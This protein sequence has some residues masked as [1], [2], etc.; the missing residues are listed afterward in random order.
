MLFENCSK[1]KKRLTKTVMPN[2]SIWHQL[3]SIKHMFAMKVIYEYWK[4]YKTK[5]SK[6]HKRRT[7]GY[8]SS[9][10]WSLLVEKQR[11]PK[12]NAI[13]CCKVYSGHILYLLISLLYAYLAVKLMQIR[14]HCYNIFDRYE[15]TLVHMLGEYCLRQWSSILKEEKF[16]R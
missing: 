8:L 2:A 15:E 9:A 12:K 16:L 1:I 7:D 13:R 11:I 4:S 6:C 5:Y 3:N 14:L 10:I